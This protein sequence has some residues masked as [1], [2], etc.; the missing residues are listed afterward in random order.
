M[1]KQVESL[2][3]KIS[4]L[5]NFLKAKYQDGYNDGYNDGFNAGVKAV[6]S[7]LAVALSVKQK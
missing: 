6:Q 7:K 2:K 1:S 4:D 5:K 3:K